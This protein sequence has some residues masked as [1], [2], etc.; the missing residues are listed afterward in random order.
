MPFKASK[1]NALKMKIFDFE[2][3]IESK[4][5]LHSFVKFDGKTDGKGPE[6]QK[7]YLDFLNGPY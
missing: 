3:E 5:D 7:L 4:L 1:S 2:L 6:S